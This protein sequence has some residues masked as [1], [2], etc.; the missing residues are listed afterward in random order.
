MDS[1]SHSRSFPGFPHIYALEGAG[2]SRGFRAQLDLDHDE[3]LALLHGETKR[4][5]P[6]RGRW[7]MGGTKPQDIIWTTYALPVLVS[8][9]VVGVLREGHFSGWDVVPVDLRDKAGEPLP[10]YYYLCIHGHCGPI[11]KSRSVKIDKI[12][13]GGVFPVWMGLYFG[14]STWDG[15]DVFMAPGK[16][17]KF[18]VEPVK[19]A[20]EKA[21]VRNVLFTPLDRVE[22]HQGPSA[23]S[24]L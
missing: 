20:L 6:I 22:S 15:S 2:T 21:K 19:R 16:G 12:F 23:A 13:P 1:Q 14:E 17:F 7:V 9:R 18:V 3:M 5:V 4:N 10:T 8:E 24:P 11:D